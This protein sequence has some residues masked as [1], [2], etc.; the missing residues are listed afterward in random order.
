MSS[1]NRKDT[2]DFKSQ[3][4]IIKKCSS[5]YDFKSHEA[6]L[7]K[8]HQPKLIEQLYKNG[9]LFLLQLFE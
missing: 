5:G 2:D 6:L 8:K 3:F 7:I 9:P 1:C 4:N